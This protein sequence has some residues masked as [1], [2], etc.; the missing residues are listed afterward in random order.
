MRTLGESAV[1]IGDGEGGDKGGCGTVALWHC[2]TPTAKPLRFPSLLQGFFVRPSETASVVRREE[3]DQG[4]LYVSVGGAF[5]CGFC[6]LCLVFWGLHPGSFGDVRSWSVEDLRPFSDFI[7]WGSIWKKRKLW[8]SFLVVVSL[9][10]CRSRFDI[11]AVRRVS[12]EWD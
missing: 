10:C 4:V 3:R 2:G 5:V 8:V 11:D 9:L 6:Y 1:N 12:A 7:G